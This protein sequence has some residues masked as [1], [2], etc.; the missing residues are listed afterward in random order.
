MK[1]EFNDVNVAV[2]VIIAASQK[3]AQAIE[4]GDYKIANKNYDRTRKAVA[5]LREN[6]G[7]E[8]LKNLLNHKETSVRLA[9][10]TF[11]L[12]HHE[13][14]AKA[15]LEE[16]VSASIPHQSFS[17]KLVLQEWRNGNLNM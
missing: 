17:A 10:V 8:N 7:I 16:I 4:T 5:Y 12:K 1:E 2:N 6:G 15:V 11:L 14:Q 13:A 9:A 3:H